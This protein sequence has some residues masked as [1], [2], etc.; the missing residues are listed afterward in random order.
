MKV[1]CLFL[2]LLACCGLNAQQKFIEVSDDKLIFL[3]G[4]FPLDGGSYLEYERTESH[5]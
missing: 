5:P 3:S 4:Y 1:L 2:G